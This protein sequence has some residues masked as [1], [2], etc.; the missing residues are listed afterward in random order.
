MQCRGRMYPHMNTIH[1][2]VLV[3]G[4]GTAGSNAARA[5]VTAGAEK[6]TLIQP[7]PLLIPV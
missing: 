6:V 2:N 3:L 1:T 4:S 7:E 5:A